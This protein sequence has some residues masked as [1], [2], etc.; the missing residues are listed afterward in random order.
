MEKQDSKPLLGQVA[1]VTGASR[2]IGAACARRLGKMGACVY[3]NYQGSE[4]CAK[5]V[6]EDIRTAGGEAYILQGDVSQNSDCDAMVQYVLEQA[7]K[8]DIL[9]N[10]AGILRDNLLVRMSEAEFEAVLDTNLKG[11]FHMMHYV[12][13]SMMRQR[14][15][16]IIN[17]ASV[18]GLLGNAGQCNYSAAKAGVIGMTKAAARELASRGI[19]V[20]AV[21]PGFIQTDMTENMHPDVLALACQQIPMKRMGKPEDVAEAVVFLASSS[22]DYITGQTLCVDGGMAMH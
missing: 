10:N 3:V 19:T 5:T 13:K 6:V 12:A 14:Y 11:V 4:D 22:A 2:G 1:L 15:G 8:I 21:A 20:N 17:I 9:V 7:G 16:K 18:S